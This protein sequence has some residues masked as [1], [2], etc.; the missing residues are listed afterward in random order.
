MRARGAV[1]VAWEGAADLS[2]FI[3]QAPVDKPTNVVLRGTGAFST[4]DIAAGE[5]LF[6]NYGADYWGER[7]AALA[8]TVDG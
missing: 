6:T 1:G 4:E 3:Q 5:E 2:R 8:R 7:L